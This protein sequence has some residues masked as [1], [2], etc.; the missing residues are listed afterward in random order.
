MEEEISV[1]LEGLMSRGGMREDRIW[2]KQK[3]STRNGG[4][5]SGGVVRIKK[6][7][8]SWLCFVGKSRKVVGKLC[9]TT[10]SQRPIWTV[11]NE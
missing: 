9:I 6:S 4:D 2:M 7:F 1:E 11:V 8:F 3:K 10:E 5:K